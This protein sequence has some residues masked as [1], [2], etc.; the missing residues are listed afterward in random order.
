MTIASNRYEGRIRP[1]YIAAR[2]VAVDR[3]RRVVYE[4]RI[5]P[6][7][8]AASRA[9]LKR[10]LERAYEGRIRPSYIAAQD[11]PKIFSQA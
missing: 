1:S 6:S 7:Y 10:D 9:E 3:T 2:E 11:G 4:G 8:I 5:R